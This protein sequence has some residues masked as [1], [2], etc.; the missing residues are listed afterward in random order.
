MCDIPAQ[1]DEPRWYSPLVPPSLSKVAITGA[2]G[3]LGRHLVSRFRDQGVEVLPLVREAGEGATSVDQVLSTPDL[4]AGCDAV[5]HAAA[6]RHRHG[7]SAA[8][9]RASNIGLTERLLRAAAGRVRR[10][11]HTSSVGVYGFPG[12]LPI[13]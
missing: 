10:F 3:F 1:P 5:V 2:A 12:D 4:L 13:R 7:V 6:I 11:V 8:E 9:Y